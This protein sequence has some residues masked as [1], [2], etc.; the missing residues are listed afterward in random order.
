MFSECVIALKKSVSLIVNRE[1]Y[2]IEAAPYDLLNKVLRETLGLT[3]T[4]KGCD[5]GGCGSCTVLLN[6]RAVYSCMIPVLRLGNGSE[7]QTIEGIS[8]GDDLHPMQ[9]SFL[10][11]FAS[12]CGFST[13]GMIMSAIGLL[14]ENPDPTED[15]IK[16]AISGNLCRCTG[17]VSIIR[18]IADAAKVQ[19]ESK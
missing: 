15:Q 12:Q 13:P 1:K 5:Y 17:Y 4:K 9:E 2:A 16:Q 19:A 10:R 14:K 6:G 7:I 11:N 18:A 3:G 8:S